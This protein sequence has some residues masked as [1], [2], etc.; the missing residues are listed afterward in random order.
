MY[1][2]KEKQLATLLLGMSIGELR[3]TSAI[4]RAQYDLLQKQAVRQFAPGDKVNFITRAGRTVHG[5]VTKTNQKTIGV[6]AS[7]GR[8][9]R[10][11]PSILK[12][13]A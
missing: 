13:V 11:G 1:H 12:K 5:V 3:E 8:N 4:V 7:D 9:W 2:E 6:L 10:V